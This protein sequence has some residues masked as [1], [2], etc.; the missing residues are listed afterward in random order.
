MKPNS[1]C[2]LSIGSVE[3]FCEISLSEQLFKDETFLERA[4]LGGQVG[5]RDPLGQPFRLEF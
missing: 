5:D 2:I 1:I 4:F 3:L